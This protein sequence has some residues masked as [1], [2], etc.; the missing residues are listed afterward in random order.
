MSNRPTSLF[1]TVLLLGFVTLAACAKSNE[2]ANPPNIV[3]G[4]K[5]AHGCLGSA[6]YSWCEEKSKCLKTWEEPCGSGKLLAIDC[7]KPRPEACTKEYLPVCGQAVLNTGE[8]TRQTYGNKCDACAAMKVVSYTV[9]A[10]EET[11]EN[12]SG[13][14]SGNGTGPGGRLAFTTCDDPRP[15]VCTTE[16]NPVCA[17]VDTGIR[18][19][20]APCP[21]TERETFATGCTACANT[22][23][24]GYFPGACEDEQPQA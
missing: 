4:D 5:D 22:N 12:P 19:I 16:Y 17:E 23:V 21:S 11:P 15:E 14:P 18:C 6:G 3:G 2:N 8:V 7:T 20:K 1:I 10:C 24:I 9:G 13:M